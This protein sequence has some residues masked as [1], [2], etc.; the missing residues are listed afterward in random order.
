MITP[1]L[2]NLYRVLKIA[3][4]IFVWVN[5]PGGM[6]LV[7]ISTLL[8]GFLFGECTLVNASSEK[9][10]CLHLS[11]VTT[12][13]SLLHKFISRG[14]WAGNLFICHLKFAH[15]PTLHLNFRPRMQARR[16]PAFLL[17]L[18]LTHSEKKECASGAMRLQMNLF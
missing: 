1:Y 6:H 7:V 5:A 15:P 4:R 12:H 14:G 10:R 3:Q 8:F 17:Q 2:L 18:Y 16:F 11:F 13:S 9:Y